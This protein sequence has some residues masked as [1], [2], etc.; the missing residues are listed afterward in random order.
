MKQFNNR[1]D[2]YRFGINP[3]YSPSRSNSTLNDQLAYKL[4]ISAIRM[5]PEIKCF[6]ETGVEFVDGTQ[7]D[8]ID[9]VVLGTGYLPEFPFLD[10]N[11]IG[12]DKTHLYLGMFPPERQIQ[13]L[14]TIGCF[15]IKGPVLPIVEMQSRLATRVFK[16]FL[17]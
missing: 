14:A 17:F 10:Q 16:V 12:E 13:T 3:K 1:I 4:L 7:I 6:T 9:A 2:H 8:N 11:V 15:R 5:K